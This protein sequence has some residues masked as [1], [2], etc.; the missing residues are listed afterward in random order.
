MDQRQKIADFL[1]VPDSLNESTASAGPLD[2]ASA[3]AAGRPIVDFIL[4][5]IPDAIATFKA[6]VSVE[7]LLNGAEVA[8]DFALGK[9]PFPVPQVVRDRLWEMLESA[10]RDLWAGS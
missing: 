8:F 9:L 3:F 10:I 1:A 2:E 4:S 6:W 7:L 5:R